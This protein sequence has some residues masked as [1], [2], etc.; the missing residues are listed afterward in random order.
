MYLDKIVFTKV[1]D[2]PVENPLAVA[3]STDVK[4]SIRMNQVNGIRFY[5]TVDQEK[6]AAL[7]A[8]GATV[9]M[10]T[11]IAPKDLL[12]GTEL[13]LD[14][15]ELATPKAVN[16]KYQAKNEDGSYNYYTEGS[17]FSGIVGTIANVKEANI[18]RDFVGRGY[19]KV[20]KGEN[21]TISYADIN[22][23]SSARSLKIVAAAI[24]G[25]DFYN[26]QL[27][28]YQRSLVDTW[29]AK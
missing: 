17:N 16:V 12:D 9:E 1:A 25:T 27:N 20:T 3:V 5:T 19:V 22:V 14:L 8:D 21:T 15:A 11:L 18:T 13:T 4:A 29:A 7:E 10:G 24:Q 2:L 28:D 26:N 6:I 23:E